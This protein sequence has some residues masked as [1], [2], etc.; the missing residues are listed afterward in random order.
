MKIFR[1]FVIIIICAITLLP[2]SNGVAFADTTTY[3]NAID[4]LSIDEKFNVSDYPV[5][6]SDYTL[7]LVQV[8]E[9][10]QKEL[11][12]YVYQPCVD[13]DFHATSVRLST[14]IYDSLSYSDYPLIWLNN[15]GSLYKYKVG[16]FTVSDS[17]ARYYVIS[18]L[19]RN[20][21]STID[22]AP[23]DVSQTIEEVP[24]DVNKMYVFSTVNGSSYVECRDI[25][26][27]NVTSKKVGFVRYLNG[28]GFLEGQQYKDCHYV[29][30]STDKPM[31]RLI[32]AKVGFNTRTAHIGDPAESG[33]VYGKTIYHELTI[34]ENDPTVTN[35]KTGHFVEAYSWK[36]I[37]TVSD[38]I[39]SE[40]KSF[41]L[42]D[43]H[44]VDLKRDTN[45][46]EKAKAELNKLS[47]VLRF[48]ETD[49]TLDTS[50][51]TTSGYVIED[52][53]RVFSV[54]VLQLEFET[55]GV[56]YNLGVIDNKQT[57]PLTPDNEGNIR[58]TVSSEIKDILELL[59]KLFALLI[60]VALIVIF[61]PVIQAIFS[62]IWAG[63]KAVFR[64]ITAPFRFLFGSKNRRR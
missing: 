48:Y 4:D 6:N 64:V 43:G 10:E 13:K 44:F 46:A 54:T 47:W 1:V 33:D 56:V 25:V 55:D 27:V 24:F 49:Y 41:M 29:A 63:I 60:V 37:Q 40:E 28:V 42:Y 45:V 53:V 61:F 30:F 18:C 58:V 22:E 11:L 57:G 5:N 21:D 20:W 23:S 39:A 32:S 12:L 19:F 51:V 8:A 9:S 2:T 36:R 52:S 26:T 59:M 15:E 35:T 38:F 34:D 16:N 31:D 50:G 3:S 17:S 62:I 14:G 7:S